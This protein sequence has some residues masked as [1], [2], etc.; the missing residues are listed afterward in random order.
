MSSNTPQNPPHELDAVERD[1]IGR[2]L[3]EDLGSGDVTT[4]STIPETAVGLGRIR[5][6]ESLIL[7]GLPYAREVFAQVD[8]KLEFET[9]VSDGDALSPGDVAATVRGS[10]RSLLIGERLALNLMQHLSGVA[11][12]T[13]RF[14]DEV[15]GTGARV[16]DTRK[17]MP[18]WR[19]A[20][21][22]AV[23]CGGGVNH[24]MALYD[25]VLIKDNHVDA[26]GSLP[27]A[28]RRAR[29]HVGPDLPIIVE[30]RDIAEIDGAVEAGAT[31]LL[32]DNMTPDRLREAVAH[33]AGRAVT[34]ASGGVELATVRAIAE[35]GVDLISI[36]AL[37]HSVIAADLNMK[38]ERL[39]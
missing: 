27:E 4:E 23:R 1:L 29:G 17:T 39:S 28:V 37:T 6:K 12:T 21:K 5:A 32:L 38:I 3:R 2:A 26:V 18:L 15:A 31:R 25:A 30:I 11:T 33:V 24:R 35:T 7:A 16:T 13:R 20:Q 36:G 8:P 10:L 19:R 22:Y 9:L 14:V 34:E